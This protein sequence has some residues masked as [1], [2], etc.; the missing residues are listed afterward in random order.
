VIPKIK[1]SN[2][3]ITVRYDEGEAADEFPVGLTEISKQIKLAAGII[4]RAICY[5]CDAELNFRPCIAE[6][7]L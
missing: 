6:Q 5:L 3:L 4:Y 2:H 1:A 7:P